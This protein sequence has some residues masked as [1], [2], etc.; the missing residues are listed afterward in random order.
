MIMPEASIVAMVDGAHVQVPPPS[1]SDKAVVL[2]GQ[3]GITPVMG[4]A[5]GFTVNTAVTVLQAVV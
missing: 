3:T 1:V 4:P 2:P 5:T